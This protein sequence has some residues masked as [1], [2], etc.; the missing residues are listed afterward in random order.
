[1]R[2]PSPVTAERKRKVSRLNP[3]K[4]QRANAAKKSKSQED[5]PRAA[6]SHEEAPRAKK[7]KSHEE[8]SASH[9]TPLQTK[10]ARDRERFERSL[11]RS[12]A[13]LP[14]IK[15]KKKFSSEVIIPSLLIKVI[16]DDYELIH[17]QR[18]LIPLPHKTSVRTIIQAY[19][20][21]K[22]CDEGELKGIE[23]YFNTALGNS[24]LY[25]F[26][27]PA[28]ADYLSSVRQEDESGS[29]YPRAAAEPIDLFGYPHLIRFLINF[30]ENVS[31]LRAKVDEETIHIYVQKLQK[32]A[33]YLSKYEGHYHRLEEYKNTAPEYHRRM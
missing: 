26:E 9:M 10:K 25:K 31:E 24:L 11:E 30:N 13:E 22:N 19:V 20:K 3:K 14:R 28:Y 33:N 7:A 21:E 16:Q 23:K 4:G 5:V 6:R 17:K 29:V 18:K 2:K 8:L 1:M 15:R 27:R 32:L 12:I